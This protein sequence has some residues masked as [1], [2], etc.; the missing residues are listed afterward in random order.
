MVTWTSRITI[1]RLASIQTNI[2]FVLNTNIP[3]FSH[4]CTHWCMRVHVSMQWHHTTWSDCFSR[5]RSARA[6]C[7]DAERLAAPNSRENIVNDQTTKQ[8]MCT[9]PASIPRRGDAHKDFMIRTEL[10]WNKAFIVCPAFSYA[11]P[12][13][14]MIP[15]RPETVPTMGQ[16]DPVI[17]SG[18][19]P[20]NQMSNGYLLMLKTFG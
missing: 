20:H 8:D 13:S 14:T 6:H 19:W 3:L 1:T 17:I 11:S 2:P 7:D 5:A 16:N 9:Y 15:L 4:T 10:Y 12:S 18:K